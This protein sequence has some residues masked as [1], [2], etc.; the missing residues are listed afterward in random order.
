MRDEVLNPHLSTVVMI[1]EADGRSTKRALE[2]CVD[3]KEKMTHGISDELLSRFSEFV[4]ARFGLH[5]PRK[6]WRDLERGLVCAAR[7]FGLKDAAGCIRWL[8]STELTR[9]ELDTLAGCL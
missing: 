3:E 7:E 8:T 5:F 4:T 1:Q 6:R 2:Q 9:S